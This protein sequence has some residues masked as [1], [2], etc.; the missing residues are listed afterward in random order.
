MNTQI[1]K[2]ASY[3]IIGY[4]ESRADGSQIGKTAQYHIVGYYDAKANITKDNQ[5]RIVGHGNL[6]ASLVHCG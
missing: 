2:D 6:L 5:Y 4:I 1:L 3:K